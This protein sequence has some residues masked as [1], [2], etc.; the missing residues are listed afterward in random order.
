MLACLK[1]RMLG[2]QW[3]VDP[4]PPK[5]LDFR[6]G[7]SFMRS[8]RSMRQ[9]IFEGTKLVLEARVLKPVLEAGVLSMGWKQ[10]ALAC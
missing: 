5:A 2:R 7:S 8:M 4:F 10:A 3:V 6:S 1:A 9:G